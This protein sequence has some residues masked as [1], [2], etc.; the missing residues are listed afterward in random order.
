MKKY[1]VIALALLFISCAT[2]KKTAQTSTIESSSKTDESQSVKTEMV[3][4][5]TKTEDGIIAVTVIEF[6]PPSEGDERN[7][8]NVENVTLEKVGNI[9]NA[10]IKRIRHTVIGSGS[11]QKGESK[12]TIE[13]ARMR[14]DSVASKDEQTSEI[15]S[16][17]APDPYRWRFIFF[18][19]ALILVA[20]VAI[21]VYVKRVPIIAWLRKKIF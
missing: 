11:E 13:Y 8:D 6:Y 7:A 1:F 18:T 21:V 3:I 9:R 17:P 20:L 10:A 16:S 5:T 15:Q 12:E 14:S 4:D 19:I 2:T